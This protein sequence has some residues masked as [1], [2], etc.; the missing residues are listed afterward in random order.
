MLSTGAYNAETKAV[1]DHL[2]GYRTKEQLI[3]EYF[4]IQ[5]EDLG[6]TVKLKNAGIRWYPK[7]ATR[8][9]TLEAFKDMFKD[10]LEFDEAGNPID[11][12]NGGIVVET[13]AGQE[14]DSANDGD[15]GVE[16]PVKPLVRRKKAD[17]QVVPPAGP[18][19]E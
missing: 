14:R 11:N 10:T 2:A 15:G 18:V 1:M 19:N 17:T 13:G 7:L 5:P 8:G 3:C 9:L 16:A 6:K 4:G 12:G